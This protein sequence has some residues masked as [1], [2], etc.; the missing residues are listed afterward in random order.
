MFVRP[1]SSIPSNISTAKRTS[2]RRRAISSLSACRVRCTNARDTDD[3]ETERA[4]CSTS[5]PTG[6]CVRR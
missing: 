3:F 6:S 5:L 4:R 1:F 2:S